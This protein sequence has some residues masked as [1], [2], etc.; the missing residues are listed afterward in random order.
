VAS[1]QEVESPEAELAARYAPIIYV[2]AQEEPCDDDGDVY[3]PGPVDL[4]L[5]DPAVTLRLDQPD[6]PIVTAAPLAADLAGLDNTHFLDY[7][8]NPRDAGCDYERSYLARPGS[9]TPVTYARIARQEGHGGFALQYWFFYYFNDWN[10]THEGDW[11]MVQ[12]IFEVETAEEALASGP[13]R[14]DYAQHGGGEH[15]GWDSDKLRRDGDRPIVY[16]GS[17]SHASYFE[18]AVYI[19]WG[20]NGTGFGCDVTTGDWRVVPLEVV[21]IPSGPAGETGEFAW[22]TYEGRWGQKQKSE[23][24]GPFGPNT[25][26]KW[27]EPFDF[28]EDTRDT[29]VTV[30]GASTFGPSATDV[31]CTTVEFG[32]NF[33]TRSAASPLRAFGILAALVA[34]IVLLFTIAWGTLREAARIY[35]SDWRLFGLLGLLLIPVGILFNGLQFLVLENPPIAVLLDVMENSRGARLA[36][37]VGTGT[38]QQ[39]LSLAVVGPSVIAATTRIWQGENPGFRESFRA[40]RPHYWRVVKSVALATAVVVVL[41]I[42]I[43]GLPLALYFLIRWL[44]APQAVV[45]E[46]VVPREALTRSTEAVRGHWWR[47]LAVA[48]VLTFVG[49]FI[50][51]L[52][53]IFIMLFW[54]GSADFVNVISSL[55]FAVTL[56]YSVIGFTVLYRKLK[57]ETRAERR[58]EAAG[59][60]VA[61]ESG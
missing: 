34:G 31:F 1:A 59:P 33:V 60:A 8:G 11:E 10:N 48:V 16:P 18:D 36:S 53:A 41:S 43:I 2:K 39:V 38:L 19:G 24:N 22:T 3:A 49:S 40:V 29:S 56:P 57:Q 26:Q 4:V 25:G 46:N 44:F 6:R 42:T 32:S 15:A 7:P 27:N 13:T 55:I 20:E 12:L 47:T 52:V 61:G 58:A 28:D 14:V 35:R 17:G 45:L 54:G 23:W 50:G 37:A 51:P 30:P 5:G 21:L 9:Q